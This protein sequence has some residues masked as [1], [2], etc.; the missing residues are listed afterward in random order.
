VHLALTY[1]P[2]VI[3][4]KNGLAMF[5]LPPHQISERL[6]EDLYSGLPEQTQQEE[7]RDEKPVPLFHR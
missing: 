5:D 7:S 1:F 2:R 3:G 6:L 4:V